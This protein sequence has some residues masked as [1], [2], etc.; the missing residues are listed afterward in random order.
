MAKS[1]WNDVTST[2]RVLVADGNQ[3][4]LDRK[5]IIFSFAT[6]VFICPVTNKIL[7]TTFK[8]ITPYLPRKVVNP[9]EYICHK[10]DYPELWHFDASQ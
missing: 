8:S 4:V 10:I 3:F 7:D 1:F 9:Q 2:A 6:K 5:K